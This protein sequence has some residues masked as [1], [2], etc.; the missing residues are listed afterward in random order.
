MTHS[1][2][3]L[4]VSLPGGASHSQEARSAVGRLV[5]SAEECPLQTGSKKKDTVKEFFHN[6]LHRTFSSQISEL[7]ENCVKVL[8]N[9]PD[10]IEAQSGTYTNVI[11]LEKKARK[12]DKT[13]GYHSPASSAERGE[14]RS[15]GLSL[16]YPLP[17]WF[18]SGLPPSASSSL[19]DDGHCSTFG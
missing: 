14:A 10:Q 18:I 17:L 5:A 13:G 2:I 6:F 3:S 12:Q 19:L 11:L 15:A 9:G 8:S 1:L 4:S 7:T 16:V